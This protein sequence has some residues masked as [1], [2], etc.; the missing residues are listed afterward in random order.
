MDEV[1]EV[2][3][4]VGIVVEGHMVDM[5]IHKKKDTEMDADAVVVVARVEDKTV[6]ADRGPLAGVV[7]ER[8][9]ED[10]MAIGAG[11]GVVDHTHD[12][13]HHSLRQC[14]RWWRWR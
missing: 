7:V 3:E 14:V 1:V 2:G 5:D 11:E 10:H 8:R 9:V 13:L 4:V 12:H 6:S